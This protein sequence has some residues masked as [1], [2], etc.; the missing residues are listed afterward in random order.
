MAG[1][2]RWRRIVV[3]STMALAM[4]MLVTLFHA[5][6]A[7]HRL[8]VRHAPAEPFDAIIVPGCPSLA[9]G[10]LSPWQAR[11]AMW[12][13]ILWERGYARNLITSGS[14]VTSPFVEA[15]AL[16][17]AL[18]LFG[19]PPDRIYLEPNAL[20]TDE[21]VYN[22]LQIARLAGW[23]R[24][25]VASDSG[26]AVGACQ[27]L[28]DWHSQCGAFSMD[29]GLVETRLRDFAPQ[30]AALRTRAVDDFVPLKTREKARARQHGRSPRP[31]S[32]VVYPLMLLRRGFGRPPWQ[33]LAP[34]SFELLTW[35][36]ARTRRAQP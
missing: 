28:E 14:A 4:S 34:E 23:Q 20:H 25:A 31:P 27:M 1:R 35:D 26:Q 3:C 2:K 30:L 22:A 12:A 36:S 33:P 10:R 16:A 17:A 21:N 24:L 8:E 13:A 15:E 19:V 11:R 7:S 32:F 5:S 9:D 29:D 6:C 18:T